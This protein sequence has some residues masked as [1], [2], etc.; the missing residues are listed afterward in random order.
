MEASIDFGQRARTTI[1]LSGGVAYG[2]TVDVEH[3]PPAFIE[4]DCVTLEIPPSAKFVVK[5]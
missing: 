5:E 4:G 3:E 2:A 1:R